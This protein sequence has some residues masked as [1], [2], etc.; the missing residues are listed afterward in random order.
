MKFSMKQLEHFDHI[1]EIPA[2]DANDVPAKIYFRGERD[3]LWDFANKHQDGKFTL[4]FTEQYEFLIRIM[5]KW[6]GIIDSD[7]NLA[8]PF[9]KEK[10]LQILRTFEIISQERVVHILMT[11]WNEVSKREEILKN[12]QAGSI[13]LDAPAQDKLKSVS[14]MDTT[15]Q[16]T[17]KGARKKRVK[18]S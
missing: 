5:V 3:W 15:Q 2:V 14:D 12:L 4:S 10:A 18:K 17:A 6:E 8:I 9:S 11:V 13:N 16:V 1:E 7:R